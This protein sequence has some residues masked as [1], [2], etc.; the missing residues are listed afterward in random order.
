MLSDLQEGYLSSHGDGE[1]TYTLLEV[2]DFKGEDVAAEL[3]REGIR[4]GLYSTNYVAV[5][6]EQSDKASDFLEEIGYEVHRI[7]SELEESEIR[8]WYERELGHLE[9]RKVPASSDD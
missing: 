5:R 2:G 9:G 4:V 7:T 6:H 8:S 1:L 3:D